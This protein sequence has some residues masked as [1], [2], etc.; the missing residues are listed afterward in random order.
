MSDH[1]THP[2]DPALDPAN[3]HTHGHTH[4]APSAIRRS[5]ENV[6]YTVGTTVDPPHVPLQ[7]PLSERRSLDMEK[8]ELGMMSD[9]EKASSSS[10]GPV[11]GG[12][13]P[14]PKMSFSVFYRKYKIF[15]HIFYFAFMTA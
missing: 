7:S 11:D 1:H 2:R 14:K 15:F 12:E 10:A 4:H 9:E 13:Q 8:K 6:T 5:S 3:Q